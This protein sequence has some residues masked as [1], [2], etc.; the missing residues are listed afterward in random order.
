MIPVRLVSAA[1][2]RMD[3]APYV[4]DDFWRGWRKAVK[5]HRPDALTIAETGHLAMATLHAN[6]A[7]QAIERVTN[8]FP[9]EMHH[10]IL[11]NLSLNLRGIISQQLRIDCVL[12]RKL[13]A[14]CLKPFHVLITELRGNLHFRF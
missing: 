4:P 3:V 1:G 2:W 9:I 12:M 7:N 13:F 11:L 6:N 5:Q 10:Q 8:F 14:E